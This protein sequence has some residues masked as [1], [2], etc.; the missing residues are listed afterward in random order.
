MNDCQV[1]HNR[2]T[3]TLG[4]LFTFNF[5][6]ALRESMDAAVTITKELGCHTP[7]V[8]T[9]GLFDNSIF[10][11][12][13]SSFSTD[14][15]KVR[16]EGVPLQKTTQHF[17]GNFCQKTQLGRRV[18]QI[19]QS[20]SV[21]GKEPRCSP[22][23]LGYLDASETSRSGTSGNDQRRT[24][25]SMAS[26]GMSFENMHR[27]EGWLLEQA[28]VS[29]CDF[30]NSLGSADFTDTNKIAY[31]VYLSAKLVGVV[32]GGNKN[33]H[34]LAQKLRDLRRSAALG[35]GAGLRF[36]SVNLDHH[37]QSLNL[38]VCSG[39]HLSPVWNIDQKAGQPLL[40]PQTL[41]IL[42]RR[43]H[44]QYHG[45]VHFSRE[46]AQ[47][48]FWPPL[49]SHISSFAEEVVE[50]RRLWRGMVASG[51]V[52]WLSAQESTISHVCENLALTYKK[53]RKHPEQQVHFADLTPLRHVGIS[54]IM[55]VRFEHVGGVRL[56]STTGLFGHSITE[57]LSAI[58]FDG[59]HHTLVQGEAPILQNFTLA[60]WMQAVPSARNELAAW[61]AYGND[62]E[63]GTL[64]NLDYMDRGGHDYEVR[65]TP[66]S[67]VIGLGRMDTLI[68]ET[69][70]KMVLRPADDDD[71]V[72]QVRRSVQVVSFGGNHGLYHEFKKQRFQLSEERP[73]LLPGGSN[74]VTLPE[75]GKM[76]EK[77]SVYLEVYM[78]DP[79]ETAQDAFAVA[80]SNL[81]LDRVR[82]ASPG[83]A[84][85]SF[86][87]HEE[88]E[89]EEDEDSSPVPFS[90]TK[91]QKQKM[92]S[93]STL[94][95][96]SML[97][98]QVDPHR[99][100]RSMPKVLLGC[101]LSNIEVQK[102]LM[103]ISKHRCLALENRQLFQVQMSLEFASYEKTLIGEKFN[104][105]TDQKNTTFRPYTTL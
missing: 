26:P 76:Y 102:R 98:F 59:I 14:R 66:K 85:P 69:M 41:Q 40:N 53:L 71:L 35:D 22:S 64:R 24:F 104:N 54:T 84:L 46:F 49:L 47:S 77:D 9:E 89:E 10:E 78:C 52:V 15:D 72:E 58:P 20:V 81:M 21:S 32:S 105:R 6:V 97:V 92:S 1:L 29:S 79:L 62:Q 96:I 44:S 63:D 48:N 25:Y 94:S 100:Y 83:L 57:K 28:E 86:L 93:T 74:I 37:D 51:A 87:D 101:N 11:K 8:P 99:P 95:E 91:S 55:C 56:V 73:C 36:M 34:T 82:D 70:S 2:Q 5:A 19:A 45:K 33:V 43:R 17:R 88:D 60:H 16:R 68:A 13:M 67:D 39:R 4:K 27:L 12:R 80:K 31:R 30:F 103:F 23:K 75:V 38:Y 61:R 3:L 90:T 50:A 65:N 7:M 18:S 42:K